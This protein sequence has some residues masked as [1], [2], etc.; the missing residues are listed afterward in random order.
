MKTALSV[1][2]LA[3]ALAVVSATDADAALRGRA[4]LTT[5]N[6]CKKC[7]DKTKKTQTALQTAYQLAVSKAPSAKKTGKVLKK[8]QDESI[9]LKDTTQMSGS[10]GDIKQIFENDNDADMTFLEMDASHGTKGFCTQCKAKLQMLMTKPDKK[11]RATKAYKKAKA[12]H[13][14]IKDTTTIATCGAE[15]VKGTGAEQQLKDST[16]QLQGEGDD[17]D[18][19]VINNC[20]MMNT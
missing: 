1:T 4:Q 17:E 16:Q 7:M 11:A 2:V 20:A 8:V 6:P 18:P 14:A 5:N 19:A 3:C 9:Q 12:I 10:D 13:K 15:E